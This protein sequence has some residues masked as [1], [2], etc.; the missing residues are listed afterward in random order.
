MN[1]TYILSYKFINI[2]GYDYFKSTDKYE[3]SGWKHYFSIYGFC[4]HKR[5]ILPK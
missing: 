2:I 1:F 3:K 4:I 5:V